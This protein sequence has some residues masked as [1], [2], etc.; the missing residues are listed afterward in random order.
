MEHKQIWEH[1]VETE[2][3]IG[4]DRIVIERREAEGWELTA[5]LALP[6]AERT[7]VLR[8]YFKRRLA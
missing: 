3:A 4:R 1:C 5:A 7:I 6:N 2:V 8:L